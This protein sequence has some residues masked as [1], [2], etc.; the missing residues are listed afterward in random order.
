MLVSPTMASLASYL[1]KYKATYI[2]YLATSLLISL[3][4]PTQLL[5]KPTRHIID[6]YYGLETFLETI[7]STI[8][9]DFQIG[10][11]I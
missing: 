8:W 2:R 10:V 5:V 11:K 3:I 6:I 1:D 9:K 4:L 7:I